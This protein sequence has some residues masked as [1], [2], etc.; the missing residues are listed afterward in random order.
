MIL[1]FLEPLLLIAL[2]CEQIFVGFKPRRHLLGLD[3]G[4]SKRSY[5]IQTLEA[6]E[7]K[8]AWLVVTP[9]GC[10]PNL[11]SIP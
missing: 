10:V 4:Q 11:N 2:T 5:S 1:E 3:L 8:L 9:L 6:R 7:Y